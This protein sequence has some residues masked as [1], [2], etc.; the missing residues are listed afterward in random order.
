MHPGLLLLGGAALGA[1][2][3]KV[4]KESTARAAQAQADIQNVQKMAVTKFEPGKSYSIQLMVTSD[5]GTRDVPTATAV[6]KSTFEQLGW[7]I[8]ST[9]VPR[10]DANV[11]KFKAGE[12]S[13]W[14]VNGVW[15]RRDMD[16]MPTVPSWLGMAMAY[17]LPAADDP[18]AVI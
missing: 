2:A 17:K 16:S 11:N 6:I 10:G 3:L 5:I 4:M 13:E 7:K 15:R 14:I 18:S 8:L 9:P 1:L 12:P